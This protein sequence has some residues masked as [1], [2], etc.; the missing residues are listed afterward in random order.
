MINVK[1]WDVDNQS[2]KYQNLA[3]QNLFVLPKMNA[4]QKTQGTVPYL[5]AV[6]VKIMLNFLKAEAFKFI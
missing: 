6:R 4:E 1:F 3:M 5:Q 2:Y